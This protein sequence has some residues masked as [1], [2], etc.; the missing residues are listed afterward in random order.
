MYTSYEVNKII[1]QLPGFVCTISSDY[2]IDLFNAYFVELFGEP[3]GR[4]CHEIF[5]SMEMPCEQCPLL[6]IFSTKE[7]QEWK[8]TSPEGRI[9]LIKGS[10]I[11][12]DG[13][14]RVL[15]IGLEITEDEKEIKRIEELEY[16]VNKSPAV[17]FLWKA[18]ENWPVEMV[19]ENI[20]IFGYIPDDFLSGRVLYSSII[21]PDDLERVAEEVEYNSDHHIDEFEQQYRIIGK[22]GDIFWI[23]DFTR[24]RRDSNGI[25]THYQGIILDITEIRAYAEKTESLSRFP[26]ENPNPVL[27]LSPDWT[28]LYAN[29][30]GKELLK[31]FNTGIDE[32]FPKEIAEEIKC[33]VGKECRGNF[34]LESGETTYL[35]SY[36]WINESGYTNI[37]CT[38]ITEL[39]KAQ[40]ELYSLYEQI[41]A[42]EEELRSNYEELCKSQ[43]DV[44]K[45]RDRAQNYLDVVGVIMVALD[46]EGRVTLI[47]KK[48][49]EILGYT[50]DEVLGTDWFTNYLNVEDTEEVR[51][52]FEDLMS[53]EIESIEFVEMPLRTKSG[54]ER[55]IAWHNTVLK[56]DGGRITGTLSS[57]EDITE[58]KEAEERIANSEARFS[59]LFNT[60][61]SGVAIYRPVDDGQDFEIVDLNRGGEEIDNIRK[62]EVIGKRLTDVFPGVG[63]FGLLDVL[64]DVFKTGEPRSFPLSE[65]KDNRISGWRDNRIY[66]LP[67]GEIVAIYDDV[68]DK[69]IAEESIRELSL[70]RER[71]IEDSEIWVV[72]SDMEGK[73]IIWN[74]GAEKITGYQRDEVLGKNTIW[75]EITPNSEDRKT[76]SEKIREIKKTGEKVEELP[77]PIRTKGGDDR[78]LLIGL[79]IINDLQGNP[80]AMVGIGADITERKEAE[81]ALRESEELYRTLAETSPGMIYLLDTSGNLRYVNSGAAREIGIPPDEITGKRLDEIFSPEM[82][83]RHMKAI[84][85]VIDNKKILH[86]EILEKFPNCDMWVDVYLAPV[87]DMNGAVTGV[88]GISNDISDRKRAEEALRESEAYIRTILDNL[89]IGASVNSVDPVVS[90]DYLNKNF[91]KYYRTT[92]D[93]LSKPDSFWDVVYED[94][95]LR[96]EIKERILEDCASGD[97]DRMYWEDIPIERAG[98]ETTYI[99]ARNI[100]IPGKDLMISTVWDVTDRKRAEDELKLS[101]MKLAE[102]MDLA[103]LVNWEYDIITDTFTFDD[104]FYALYGTNAKRE[105]GYHM[106]S[107]QYAR[108]FVHPDDMHY[109]G[110]EVQKAIEATDPGFLSDVEHRIIRRDGAIRYLAVRIGVI[111]DENGRNIKTYGA[112]QD[113][114]KRKLADLEVIKARTRLERIIEFLPDATFVLDK[115]SRVIAWNR[116]IEDMTGVSHNEIIGEG[117]YSYSRTFYGKR[118]PILIDYVLDPEKELP[119]RYK[120]SKRGR[121][122]ITAEAYLPNLFGGRGAHVLGVASV[123]YDEDGNPDGAI[124][125]IR[126]ISELKNKENEL[127]E[128]LDEKDVIIKEIHHRVK[129]NLQIIS[130]LVQLQE[131]VME[132][133]IAKNYFEDLNS[134]IISMARVYENLY[135][136][137]KF[138]Q[139]DMKRLVDHLITNVM[140][141][142]P[143]DTD[144]SFELDIMEEKFDLNTAVSLSLIISELFVNVIKHAFVGRDKGKV[145]VSLHR[146]ETGV[147]E[148]AVHDDGVGYPG[149]TDISKAKTLGMKLISIVVRDN[150]HGTVDV[151]KDGGTKFIILFSRPE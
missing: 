93:A 72:V 82:A 121:S 129:N 29:E 19:S 65:Y 81:E 109:V 151:I 13:P 104:R 17:V 46:A 125:S 18:E 71:I 105:G 27:R 94:P 33:L 88:L 68:T 130:A 50:E 2:T 63:E 100:P 21:H 140:L 7:P 22:D 143:H 67:S 51:L 99:S 54:N 146:T 113:I 101:Q 147:Y 70:F 83:D 48:G 61:R 139:I 126:D 114:T 91:L 150:L 69:K 118:V 148:L 5:Y 78:F 106:S 89:P 23:N 56:D 110:K 87:M 123:L 1:D 84:R 86:S 41:S 28:V 47:N 42:T 92:K 73:V 90:F 38:D 4:K 43:E 136:T 119:E 45:E 16:V 137:G 10:Y 39:K 77:F 34:E 53:G 8:W 40:E 124:E 35:V 9:F 62:E 138:L 75:K 80:S 58:R 98:E 108:E 30:A 11:G 57:G 15:E 149:E 96:E 95:V 131:S 24:I 37:Y 107:E 128:S 115:Q 111:Q 31:G 20:S 120:E 14:G 135:A 141:S 133:E 85:A 3:A 25:I 103:N 55:M 66:G 142:Y 145:E 49:C 134:R 36:S 64:R 97:P 102:A 116:A 60:M 79:K 6:P 144:I 76:I 59:E 26:A 32:P 122:N 74:E 132:D 52:L 12:D 112:N 117:N 44:K 127:L